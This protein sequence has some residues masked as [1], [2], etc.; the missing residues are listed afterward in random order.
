[1]LCKIVTEVKNSF[2]RSKEDRA[3]RAKKAAELKNAEKRIEEIELLIAQT[4]EEISAPENS[5]DFTLLNEKCEYLQKL[6]TDLDELYI[7]WEELSYD[8]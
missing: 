6:K 8:E 7:I 2:Y 5:S 3:K 1:M 4:E